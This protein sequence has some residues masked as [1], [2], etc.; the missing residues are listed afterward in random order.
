MQ[1]ASNALPVTLCLSL[2]ATPLLKVVAGVLILY[3]GH[4]HWKNNRS[5]NG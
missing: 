3:F 4:R 5:E 1:M 2:I